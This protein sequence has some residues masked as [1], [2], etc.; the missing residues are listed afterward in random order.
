MSEVPPGASKHGAIRYTT[1]PDP[2]GGSATGGGTSASQILGRGTSWAAAGVRGGCAAA[3]TANSETV[4]ATIARRSL[5]AKDQPQAKPKTM[6]GNHFFRRRLKRGG[7]MHLRPAANSLFYPHL[8]APRDACSKPPSTLQE[9]FMMTA[10][11]GA[12]PIHP[13]QG[14]AGCRHAPEQR[15]PR[16][17]DRYV[18]IRGRR[19]SRR[20]RHRLV[21]SGERSVLRVG[22]RS[23]KRGHDTHRPRQEQR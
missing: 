7:R 14:E 9:G 17:A 15:P 23:R 6:L 2:S 16:A 21:R 5:A 11:F 19:P 8:V 1:G 3:D 13:D 20:R 18:D 22:R 4:A 10:S 12:G